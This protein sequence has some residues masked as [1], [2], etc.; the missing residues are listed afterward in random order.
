M[1]TAILIQSENQKAKNQ[2][3]IVFTGSIILTIL[4]SLVFLQSN[5]ASSLHLTLWNQGSF[6]LE[7][8][9]TTYPATSVF[10]NNDLTAGKHHLKI[11]QVIAGQR[12][13]TS[14]ERVVYNGYIDI[15][16]NT[17]VKATVQVDQG[18]SIDN[19]R[20]KMNIRPVIDAGK[21]DVVRKRDRTQTGSKGDTSND[22]VVR[23]G[24]RTQTGSKGDTSK[25]EVIQ[26]GDRTQTGIK[27]D[28]TEPV[29]KGDREI[30]STKEDNTSSESTN[31]PKKGDKVLSQV[32]L[33]ILLDKIDNAPLNKKKA[34]LAKSYI[35]EKRL[36]NDQVEKIVNALPA[37]KE[38]QL[39]KKWAS[40]RIA[41]TKSTHSESKKKG[42]EGKK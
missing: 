30:P 11:T 28:K 2:R 38:K 5:A 6:V 40:K 37:K 4:F 23:K 25:E 18:L 21:E 7:L 3:F 12:G 33:N 36:R 29:F 1:K 26:K 31:K 19:V 17:M 10:T 14:R 32:E 9:R 41:T 42:S 13:K 27:S 24:D 22:D 8:D 35:K 16:M 15:P 34:S 20:N 39:F